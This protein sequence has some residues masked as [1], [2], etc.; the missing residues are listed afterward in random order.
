MGSPY[1]R[2]AIAAVSAAA[3]ALL[4]ALGLNIGGILKVA[5][6]LTGY[7]DNSFVEK[8]VKIIAAP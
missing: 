2:T 6:K 4:V 5:P 3:I 1:R 7:I 8:A